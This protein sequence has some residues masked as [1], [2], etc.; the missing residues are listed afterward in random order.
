MARRT[1][2]S[3]VESM[4][5]QAAYGDQMDLTVERYD[6]QP[7]ERNPHIP[8]GDWPGMRGT[9]IRTDFARIER[10]QFTSVLP[11]VWIDDAGFAELDEFG[12]MPLDDLRR[13]L[14]ALGEAVDVVTRTHPTIKEM[15]EGHDVM[16]ANPIART[17]VVSW[18]T[19][20]DKTDRRA[21]TAG[22]LRDVIADLPDDT[23]VIV[24]VATNEDDVVDEQIIVDAG[25]GTMNWGDGYGDEPDPIFALECEW[26]T[27]FNLH[28][29]PDR[30]RP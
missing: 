11:S 13:W 30:P 4:T 29:H 12:R 26:P 28:I 22:Q 25:H 15:S 6:H 2:V 9:V 19:V 1:T 7:N 27:T 18:D 20:T 21:Y 3:K 16:S 5:D 17:G 10:S 23:P 8:E 24:H 14:A